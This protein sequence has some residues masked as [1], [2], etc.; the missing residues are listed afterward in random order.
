MGVLGEA[1][2][3]V[4]ERHEVLR[5]VFGEVD[6][7]PVQVV[8]PAEPVGV[9]LVESGGGS[10][11]ERLAWARG[12]VG[13]EVGR[14]F[15]LSVGPLVRLVV[16]RLGVD[17]HV[18][19][20][21]MH[22]IVTDAWSQGVVWGEL[23]R[24]YGELI[25]GRVPVLAELPVQYGDFAVWQREWLSGSVLAEQWG[26]WEQRLAGVSGVLE[27]P[28]DR[29]RLPVA[30]FEG[31]ACEWRIPADVVER[32]RALAECENATLFMVLLA[33]FKVVLA[34][35]CGVEDVVVGSPVANRPR[36]EL[37][38]LVGFFINTLVLR[39]DVSGD[40]SFRAL[41]GRVREGALGAFA[42]QDLPFEYLVER[43]QPERDLSR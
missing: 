9:E 43:L 32:A 1:L 19:V 28:G 33:A 24:A 39:T 18:V 12:V 8:L 7:S 15:D 38:G 37:E 14:G 11:G 4:V 20:L 25:A 5:T 30:S 21:T 35:Y 41:V 16:A 17:D 22:H 40:P 42:H 29:P 2:S 10:L 13:R 23:S 3:L 36:R 26:Y 31:G 6:G 27:L 34:R